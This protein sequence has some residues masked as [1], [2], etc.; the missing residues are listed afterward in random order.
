[1]LEDMDTP[2]PFNHPA[3]LA[4]LSDLGTWSGR[5][6]RMIEPV[7]GDRY[8][9]L[10]VPGGA[11]SVEGWS[12]V[13]DALADLVESPTP[14]GALALPLA[15]IEEDEN[16]WL[17][18]SELPDRSF[19]RDIGQQ[20]G[21]VQTQ[22]LDMVADLA[23]ALG[24]LHDRGLVLRRMSLRDVL[25][26]ACS[27]NTSDTRGLVGSDERWQLLVSPDSGIRAM[28][29][30]RESQEVR[31]DLIMLGTAAATV[32]TGR[33]PVA[34]RPRAALRSTC[35]SLPVAAL[36]LLDSLVDGAAPRGSPEGDR[37]KGDTARTG[38][39]R[40]RMS[41]EGLGRVTEHEALGDRAREVARILHGELEPY[42]STGEAAVPEVAGSGP[43]VVRGP[44]SED[45]DRTEVLEPV[46]PRG[47]VQGA[48]AMSSADDER[49]LAFAAARSSHGGEVP[50]ADHVDRGDEDGS[51]RI[52]A[53]LNSREHD[54]ESDGHFRGLQEHPSDPAVR[55]QLETEVPD[56]DYRDIPG[57]RPWQ[58]AV[59]PHEHPVHRWGRRRR[60]TAD[61]ES[62]RPPIQR[63]TWV[64]A[65]AA[66][67]TVVAVVVSVA[68][69]LPQRGQPP[70]EDSAA[71]AQAGTES[72]SSGGSSAGPGATTPPTGDPRTTAAEALPELIAARGVALRTR[73]DELLRDVYVPEAQELT[74][75]QTTLADLITDPNTGRHAFSGLEMTVQGEPIVVAS[76]QNE[77]TLHT[78]VTATGISG[79][80]PETP[81]PNETPA[82]AE[83]A[84]NSPEQS[85]QSQDIEVSML[86]TARGWRITGVEPR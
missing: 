27:T 6:R 21:G 16:A 50:M 51:E 70:S 8:V 58:R 56:H 55:P 66:A 29:G 19:A 12:R 54:L 77:A 60:R 40:R 86:L 82:E 30:G 35:P 26:G 25:Y 67:L 83:T 17:V 34:G 2:Q 61:G 79:E 5:G 48:D 53:L 31:G 72:E 1:M 9:L 15:V 46:L 78:T 7:S 69:L 63:S 32:L 33:R 81:G 52:L 62:K 49:G 38:A 13:I 42:R 75:D 74:E 64:L 3:G 57:A 85:V 11:A 73:D 43:G 10:P 4:E 41:Q 22:V 18:Y 47:T 23:E 37:P 76:S 20:G 39:E 44:D 14:D 59:P 36:D 45:L 80:S 65:G 24:D 71:Q 68:A 28:R 84:P